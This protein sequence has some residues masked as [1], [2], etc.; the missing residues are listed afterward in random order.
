MV[1]PPSSAGGD[2]CGRSGS[3]TAGSTVWLIRPRRVK[4][5][6]PFDMACGFRVPGAGRGWFGVAMAPAADP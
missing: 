5:C 3:P 6:R 1:M 2:R 4:V